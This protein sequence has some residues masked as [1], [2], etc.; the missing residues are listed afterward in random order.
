MLDYSERSVNIRD[1]R[2]ALYRKCQC[3][4]GKSPEHE[5]GCFEEMHVAWISSVAICRDR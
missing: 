1:D 3:G 5:D 4:R 2:V